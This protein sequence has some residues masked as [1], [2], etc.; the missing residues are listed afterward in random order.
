M[1][2]GVR[3]RSGAEHTTVG[4]PR[5]A[6]FMRVGLT[7]HRGSAGLNSPSWRIDPVHRDLLGVRSKGA[8][9]PYPHRLA[10]RQAKQQ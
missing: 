7:S 8:A 2:T 1:P 10:I 9:S 6:R 4:F 3:T 5:K